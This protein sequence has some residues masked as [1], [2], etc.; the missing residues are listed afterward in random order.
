VNSLEK[1]KKRT[2][3]TLTNLEEKRTETDAKT[4]AFLAKFRDW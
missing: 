2:N 4:L 3:V 1:E